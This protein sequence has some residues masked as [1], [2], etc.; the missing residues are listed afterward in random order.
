[1][2]DGAPPAPRPSLVGS[3]LGSQS[4][5]PNLDSLRQHRFVLGK[6]KRQHAVFQRRFRGVGRKAFAQLERPTEIPNAIFTA[7]DLAVLDD[8]VADLAF[9]GQCAYLRDNLKVLRPH[10]G[11]LRDQIPVRRGFPEV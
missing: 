9:D 5:L 10:T 1:M 8:T 3:C 2:K 6:T 4:A 11:K 7:P